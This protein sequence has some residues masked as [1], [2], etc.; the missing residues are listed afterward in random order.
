MAG[1]RALLEPPAGFE[2]FVPGDPP[3]LPALVVGWTLTP[4]EFELFDVLVGDVVLVEL[5]VRAALGA[6]VEV[7]VLAAPVLL[8]VL[9]LPGV[10]AAED[11]REE[12]V[13]R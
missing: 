11:V 10:A 13:D 1:T 8:V 4:P 9:A 5:G 6:L 7:G 3:E 2:T 12:V